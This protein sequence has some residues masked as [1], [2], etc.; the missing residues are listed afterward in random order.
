MRHLITYAS[1][2]GTTSRAA[3]M[4]YDALKDRGQ[5]AELFDLRG[6]VRG[7]PAP[8]A[9][10][11]CVWIGSPVYANHPL[12]HCLE[13]IRKSASSTGAWCVPFVTWGGVSTGVALEELARE[14]M[15]RGMRLAGGARVLCVHS[16]LWRENAPPHAH[17]PDA[18]E[19]ELLQELV[20]RVLDRIAE[21]E[22]CAIEPMLQQNRAILDAA[23]TSGMPGL[24][25]AVPPPV[26]D[27]FACSGCGLCADECPVAA[28]SMEGAQPR[29]KIGPDCIRCRACVRLCPEEALASDMAGTRER[30]AGLIEQFQ[31]P[32]ETSIC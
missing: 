13:F 15:A 11:V 28:I 12:P 8:V 9:G 31:E 2:A 3:T 26:L 21:G 19:R 10:S 7:R 30:L 6:Y 1:P 16:S 32:A 25:K 27:A 22:T 20:G 29:P 5:K 18:E 24:R 14:A 17:R 23:A 4:I